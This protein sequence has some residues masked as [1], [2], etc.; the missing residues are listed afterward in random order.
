MNIHTPF[1]KQSERALLHSYISEARKLPMF[2]DGSIQFDD[3]RWNIRGHVKLSSSKK[4][5]ALSFISL[6]E[7]RSHGSI[8][9]LPNPLGNTIKA[10]IAHSIHGNGSNLKSLSTYVERVRSFKHLSRFLVSEEY[11]TDLLEVSADLVQQSML[12]APNATAMQ[13]SVVIR[14]LN[15]HGIAMHLSGLDFSSEQPSHRRAGEIEGKRKLLLTHEEALCIAKSFHLATEPLDQLTTSM[16]ALLMCSPSR[17]GELWRLPDNLEVVTDPAGPEYDA[18]ADIFAEAKNYR[19]GLRWFPEKGGKPTIKFVPA[20]MVPVAKEAIA[21]LKKL[22]GGARETAKWIIDNPGSM[23]LPP[24]LH[25]IRDK[26][27]L[28]RSELVDLLGLINENGGFTNETK[29]FPSL[30][31]PIVQAS[32]YNEGVYDFAALEKDWWSYFLKI[33]PDWPYVVIDDDIGYRLRADEALFI[34]YLR[35]YAGNDHGQRL[36]TVT[37]PDPNLLHS[38]LI[39]GHQRNIFERLGIK[40]ESG[41]YPNITTHKLRRW[42]NTIAQR[43][44]IPQS[45]IA[46]WS[47]RKNIMQNAD[48]DYRTPEEVLEELRKNSGRE[49]DLPS[50]EVADPRQEEFLDGL[51]RTNFNSTPFGYCV[52]DLFEE[53]CPSA[54]SCLSCSRLVCVKGANLKLKTLKE[55]LA[56]REEAL[57]HLEERAASGKKVNPRRLQAARDHVEHGRQLIATLSDPLVEDGT[58]IRNSDNPDLADFSYGQR[59]TSLRAEQ[60]ISEDRKELD[61]GEDTED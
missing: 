2:R 27:T 39:A 51:R 40:L 35:Q 18:D 30:R 16:M 54:M 22:S 25:H 61:D 1:E 26:G 28:T 33:N 10:Y 5:A 29:K 37:T 4:G 46:E 58:L 34:C 41:S 49:F 12:L 43:A 15:S 59:V 45:L 48:Y 42:L 56:R 55:D 47:G 57:R 9:P 38:S 53:P 24:H 50:V 21:R 36:H 19:Y 3:M 17:S 14:E 6:S 52:G 11:A 60:Q 23:P 20:P 32:R 44:G 13:I 31:N 7:T 8:E